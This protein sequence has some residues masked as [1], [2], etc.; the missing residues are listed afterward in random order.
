MLKGIE[1]A[2]FGIIARLPELKTGKSGTPYCSVNVGVTVGQDEAGKDTTQW[3]RVTVF[4]AG[5]GQP[6]LL[7]GQGWRVGCPARVRHCPARVRPCV[8]AS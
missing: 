1:C 2:G 5:R 3:V 6:L 4:N 7:R 8:A